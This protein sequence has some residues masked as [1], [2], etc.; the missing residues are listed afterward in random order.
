MRLWA[1][2]IQIVSCLIK[3]CKQ[4]QKQFY[5][6]FIHFTY[7][8]LG[9]W[10]FE[11]LHAVAKETILR[12][13]LITRDCNPTFTIFI[14]GLP[15][16]SRSFDSVTSFD[17]GRFRS[18]KIP[19]ASSVRFEM[20]HLYGGDTKINMLDKTLSIQQLTERPHVYFSEDENI[21]SISLEHSEWQDDINL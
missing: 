14:N 17:I 8:G 7:T 9:W 20:F 3:M 13:N 4:L 2:V 16:L 12:C 11:H 6:Y 21:N 1:N 18:P 19:K 10:S 5:T 15:A